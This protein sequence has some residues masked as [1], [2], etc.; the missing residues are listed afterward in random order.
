MDEIKF[1]E[2]MK[3]VSY[4]NVFRIF[5]EILTR[6]VLNSGPDCGFPKFCFQ[7]I[8][9]FHKKNESGLSMLHSVGPF[10]LRKHCM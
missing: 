7:V 9:S 4:S 10:V 6:K 5:S 2:R 3:M 8:L 1:Y